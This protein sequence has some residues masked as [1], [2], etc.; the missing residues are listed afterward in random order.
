M[1]L[2]D[3]QRDN[4]RSIPVFSGQDLSL[5]AEWYDRLTSLLRSKGRRVRQCLFGKGPFKGMV[6]TGGDADDDLDDI[7]DLRA[8]L[9][10]APP[11]PLQDEAADG[12]VPPKIVDLDEKTAEDSSAKVITMTAAEVDVE[13]QIK[14]NDVSLHVHL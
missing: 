7:D 3:A 1:S 14:C 8:E 13:I 12:Y 5:F 6:F 10:T 9:M 11:R 2:R 4:K